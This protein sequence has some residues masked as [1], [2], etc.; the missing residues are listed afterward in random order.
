VSILQAADVFLHDEVKTTC[1]MHLIELSHGRSVK[2]VDI[3]A[4][5]SALVF[6]IRPRAFEADGQMLQISFHF[7]AREDR[8]R[9]QFCRV[10]RWRVAC[11]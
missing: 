3:H 9:G 2:R 6:G 4:E 1:V 5:Q 8:D 10:L 11:V 7:C